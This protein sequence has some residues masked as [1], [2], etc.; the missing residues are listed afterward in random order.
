MQRET[1]APY[2]WI[3]QALHI[4]YGIRDLN[5]EPEIVARRMR[6]S[7][8][9]INRELAK[10]A[11]V[12]AYLV[13][14]G[15]EAKYHKVPNPS[16]GRSEQ[17]F[18]EMVQRLSSSAINRKAEKEKKLIRDA[19]FAAIRDERGY[20]DVRS[21]IKQFGQNVS[22][23]AER[24]G[25]HRPI[26]KPKKSPKSDRDG[27][28]TAQDDPLRA[29]AKQAPE[30]APEVENLIEALSDKSA[31]PLIMDIVEGLEEEEKDA[32]RQQLPLAR[33]QHALS[34]LR[35][36]DLRNAEDLDAVLKVLNNLQ[37][38]IDHLHAAIAKL[39]AKKK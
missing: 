38:E 16:G 18:E 36:V 20:Q 29:L 15:D 7:V 9:D 10:L 17:S 24:L 31:T 25:Q 5:E 12:K 8:A 22:K 33:V 21:V 19:C 2:D 32:K 14:A 35:Q 23:I 6:K 39:Q 3:D 1:K 27:T 26:I 28:K 37:N 34:D 30:C 11:L 4:E 13:W